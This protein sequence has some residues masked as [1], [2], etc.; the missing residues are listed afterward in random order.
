MM[1]QAQAG[2]GHGDV[3]FIARFDDIVIADGAAGLGDVVDTAAMSPFDVVTEGEE[4]IAAQG[5]AVELGNPGFLFFPCERFR[6]FREQILPDAV[7]QDVFVIIRDVDVDSVVTVRAADIVAER[8]IQDFRILAEPPDIGFVTSQAR[9]VD[10]GLL[11]GADADGHAVFDVADRVGLSVFQGDEGDHQIA[12]GIGG[13]ILV[14]RRDI[15]KEVRRNLS[16][17]AFLFKSDAVD[18]LRFD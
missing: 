14:F 5:D 6:F 3:V 10:A 9:A 2:H 15:L 13:D 17:V 11:T 16:F 4:S 1:E 8:Q 12:L 7:G 18:F